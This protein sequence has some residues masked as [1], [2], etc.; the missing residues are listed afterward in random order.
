MFVAEFIAFLVYFMSYHQAAGQ[1]CNT[2]IANKSL[3]NSGRVHIIWGR[4]GG[5][6]KQ[7]NKE[8]HHSCSVPNIIR[9]IKSRRMRWVE[10][11]W[12]KKI[13]T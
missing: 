6:K 2:E 12:E 5:W 4:T 13:H 3:Q 8:L 7:H 1:N 9:V 11:T 10:H